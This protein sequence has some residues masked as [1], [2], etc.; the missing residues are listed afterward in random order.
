M[1]DEKEYRETNANKMCVSGPMIACVLIVDIALLSAWIVF[2]ARLASDAGQFI[3]QN[4]AE[5]I[6]A[7]AAITVLVFGTTAVNRGAFAKSGT[8]YYRRPYGSRRTD[9]FMSRYQ[10]VKQHNYSE[11]NRVLDMLQ[12]SK[13]GDPFDSEYYRYI[14]ILQGKYDEEF[15]MAW[16]DFN[17]Y[18]S[19]KA[20]RKEKKE[21]LNRLRQY[22]FLRVYDEYIKDKQAL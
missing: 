9:I 8:K 12:N 14:S 1:N 19:R 7:L 20:L 22:V 17:Y 4:I 2:S 5:V 16:N 11:V 6:S 15:N 21:Y 18:N 13:T 3:L 10:E